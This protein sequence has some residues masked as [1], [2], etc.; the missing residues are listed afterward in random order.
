MTQT[1]GPTCTPV[2]GPGPPTRALC[3]W[4]WDAHWLSSFLHIQEVVAKVSFPTGARRNRLRFRRRQV[5][6][7]VVSPVVRLLTSCCLQEVLPVSTSRLGTLMLIE[8]ALLGR[9]RLRWDSRRLEPL[10]KACFSSVLH[11]VPVQPVQF[12]FCPIWLL[13]QAGFN[14]ANVTF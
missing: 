4:R 11:Q 13:P 6:L 9:N 5:G 10:K 3:C 1:A 7:G 8:P 14:S 2:L 12:C